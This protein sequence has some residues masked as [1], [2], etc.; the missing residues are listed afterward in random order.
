[1]CSSASRLA[2]CEPLMQSWPSSKHEGMLRG[3]MHRL[4]VLMQSGLSAHEDF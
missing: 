4:Q 1:M 2:G 3:S